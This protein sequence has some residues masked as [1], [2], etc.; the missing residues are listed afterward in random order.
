MSEP[1][2]N[3]AVIE[4]KHHV[5]DAGI[6]QKIALVG[7]CIGI[8]VCFPAVPDVS[9]PQDRIT[10]QTEDAENQIADRNAALI[11]VVYEV[12][13]IKSYKCDEQPYP[14][15]YEHREKQEKSKQYLL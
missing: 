8:G 14:N 7:I 2:E 6:Q 9:I 10:G 5:H 1:H 11:V 4:Y 15:R 13:L 3:S 12:S